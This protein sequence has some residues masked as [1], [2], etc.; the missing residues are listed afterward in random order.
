MEKVFIDF[1]KLMPGIKSPWNPAILGLGYCRLVWS[2]SKQLLTF[3]KI[4]FL[5]NCI[6]RNV[7]FSSNKICSILFFPSSLK[8][9]TKLQLKVLLY[10]Q[11]REEGQ[12]HSPHFLVRATSKFSFFQYYSSP[13]RKDYFLRIGPS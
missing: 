2:V 12:P 5:L 11:G 8:A 13:P 3:H 1:K 9:L 4:S 7:K 6:Q 10:F